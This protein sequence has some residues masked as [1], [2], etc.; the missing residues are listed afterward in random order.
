VI[1]SALRACGSEETRVDR[2]AARPTTGHLLNGGDDTYDKYH[3]SGTEQR[4][5]VFQETLDRRSTSRPR[6]R[7]E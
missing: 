7:D 4:K 3:R 5:A 1:S 2:P 6:E